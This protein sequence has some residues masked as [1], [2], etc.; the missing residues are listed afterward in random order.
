MH[1]HIDLIRAH[2][3][4]PTRLN[5]LET[6][7]HHRRRIDSDA[8]A[9][10]PVRMRQRLFGRDVGQ[11]RQRG[12]S[13]RPARRCQHQPPHF[14][15]CSAA[16]ALMHGVVFAIHGQKLPPPLLSSPPPHS[17]PPHHTSFFPT[18]SPL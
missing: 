15:V 8:V 10:P 12:L 1:H 14:S 13:K 3:K 7:I 11:R 6:L 18:P 16:Q 17:P 5:N 9:H 2:A 4:Q